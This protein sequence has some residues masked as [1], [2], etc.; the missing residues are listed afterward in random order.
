MNQVVFTSA[1]SFPHWQHGTSPHLAGARNFTP[2]SRK[3]L[4]I[5]LQR[6]FCSI[7]KDAKRIGQCA[8]LHV[9][10]FADWH[11]FTKV[12]TCVLTATGLIAAIPG[13]KRLLYVILSFM[14]W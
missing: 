13:E 10:N 9:G 2:V 14:V 1:D 5:P 3:T 8:M 12:E 6:R 4:R 11:A 7:V